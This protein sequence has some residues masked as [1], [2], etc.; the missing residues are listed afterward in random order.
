MKYTS[1]FMAQIPKVQIDLKSVG[2]ESGLFR[3][4]DVYRDSKSDFLGHADNVLSA[5]VGACTA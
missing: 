4:R 2:V 5:L 1:M 3:G